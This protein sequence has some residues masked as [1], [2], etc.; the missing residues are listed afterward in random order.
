MR[1]HDRAA[2]ANAFRVGGRSLPGEHVL[3]SD[4]LLQLVGKTKQ[5]EDAKD[6]IRL[7]I[8]HNAINIYNACVRW[9]LHN[10]IRWLQRLIVRLRTDAQVGD[11]THLRV[12]D[13]SVKQTNEFAHKNYLAS[14]NMGRRCLLHERP[15]AVHA[16][17]PLGRYHQ[18]SMNL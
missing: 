5:E 2:Y 15:S 1:H 3:M 4:H 14:K 6:F 8:K 7:A 12:N 10:S 9:W 18:K 13:T 16:A 11:L 17:W